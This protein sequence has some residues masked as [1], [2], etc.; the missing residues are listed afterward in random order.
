MVGLP[1]AFLERDIISYVRGLAAGRGEK[2]VRG[3]GDDCAVIRHGGENVLLITTD[4]LAESVH[5][6]L[7]WHPAFTLGRKAASVNISDVAA[8]GGR[9]LMALLSLAVPAGIQSSFLDELLAGFAA[10]LA[11]YDV[12]LVGGDTIASGGRLTISV[13]VIGEAPEGRVLYR[14]GARIGDLIWVSGALGA[15][16]AGLDL[17]RL[18]QGGQD[19]DL[20]R[21]QEVLAAHL[22]PEP[23]VELGLTL[24]ASGFVGAMMDVSDGLGTDL[25]HLCKESGVGAEVYVEQLPISPVVQE[26]AAS[27]KK[28]ALDWAIQ[29]GEDYQLLFTTPVACQ[30]DLLRLV[31]EQG[32]RH[33]YCIGKVVAGDKV[34]LC[35]PGPGGEIRTAIAYQGFDHFS[36]RD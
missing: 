33:I 15:A 23:Q 9:P 30:R 6:D 13:T 3:I 20:S 4:M 14:N 34:L 24:A 19:I 18:R 29:G 12:L 32:G 2:L 10:R 26:F 7:N 21:Y 35:R 31:T 27:L 36:G 11:E 8:M 17:C 28:S 25:A 5:F 16:A 1:K 22:D